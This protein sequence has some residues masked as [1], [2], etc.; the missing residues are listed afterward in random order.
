ML[1]HIP[2]DGVYHFGAG[3]GVNRNIGLGRTV[4]RLTDSCI[5][6]AQDEYGYDE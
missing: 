3:G 5:R 2:D 6:K 1:L 4:L